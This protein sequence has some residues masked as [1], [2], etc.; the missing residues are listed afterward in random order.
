MPLESVLGGVLGVLI[1][2]IVLDGI[3]ALLERRRQRQIN[4][5]LADLLWEREAS[6]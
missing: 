5:G 4:R 3:P 1:A 2:R 6:E